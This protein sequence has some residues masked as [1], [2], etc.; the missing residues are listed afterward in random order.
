[1]VGIRK[2]CHFSYFFSDPPKKKWVA[3]DPIL[4]TAGLFFFAHHLGR[5]AV[6]RD[7]ECPYSL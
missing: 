4:L 1:M 5:F 2:K 7:A 3:P 6:R